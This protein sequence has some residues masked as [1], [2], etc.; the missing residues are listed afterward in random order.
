MPSDMA[1][2]IVYYRHDFRQLLPVSHFPMGRPIP[3]N[4]LKSVFAPILKSQCV[5][6][7]GGHKSVNR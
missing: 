2:F 7:I 1:K 6:N 3:A 5:I 4:F